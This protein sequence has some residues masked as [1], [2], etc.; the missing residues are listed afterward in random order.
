MLIKNDFEVAAAGRQG[1][2][3]LRRH[4]AGGRLPA[5]RRAD[6]GPRRRQVRGPG[7]GPDG[8]GQAA[9]RRHGRDHR[10]RRGR[11]ADRG[12]RGRRRREGPRPGRMLVT[13]T[14]APAGRG[15]KVDVAQDLQLSGAA[16]QYG[17]GM[18]SDVTAVL[19]RDFAANMQA[20][21]D[22]AERG[23]SPAQ[24][25]AAAPAERLRARAAGR[26]DGAASG[27]SAVLPALPAQP[28]LRRD[29][30]WSCGGSATRSCC[31]SSC[32]SSSALLNRVLA[33]L[34]RI[35][36]ASDD[37]L[38][39]GVALIGELDGVPGGAGHDRPHR[40]GS[41]RRRGPVRRLRRQASRLSRKGER[42][43]QQPPG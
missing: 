17:R 8:P 38:A 11:Q 15:T 28:E 37:I 26:A 13:A 32:R 3:V 2:A 30:P 24:V 7:R 9:V 10:A 12:R 1:L 21:I 25:A 43:C 42:P 22:A 34:E 33:A 19:M 20:R 23:E 6:R 27:S 40:Q 39:G 16:A 29:E 18:I 35:R 36:G 31:W 5:R 4:P 41:R 14:L